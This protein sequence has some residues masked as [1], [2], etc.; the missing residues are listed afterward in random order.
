MSF[1]A[2]VIPVFGSQ[3]AYADLNFAAG[4]FGLDGRIVNDITSLPGFTFTRA[5]LA[6]GYDATG[7]LTYG[8][9]NLCLQ[10]QTFDNAYWTKTAA[11]ITADATT[12][13]DG[14]LTA[15]RLIEDTSTGTHL[16]NRDITSSRG[17]TQCYSIYLKVGLGSARKYRLEWFDGASYVWRGTFDPATNTFSSI[18]TAG[19]AYGSVDVGNGWYRVYMV[20]AVAN[21]SASTL[22]NQYLV[23]GASTSY[24]GDGTSGIYLWGAQLEA[25][26]YQTTPSTYYP[27]TSAAY[28]G[29]RLVYDPVTLAS[30]GILVEEART[31]VALQ[32]NALGTTPWG[33]TNAGVGTLPTVTNNYAISP[34]GT[35]NA[36]RIQ[37]SL[38]GGT[39][40]GD[41]SLVA[42]A[43]TTSG[44]AQGSF[45]LKTTD[46]ST[47]VVYLRGA[48]ATTVTVTGTWQR[49]EFAAST[50]SG[51]QFAVGL[52]GGQAL[53]CSNTC[54]ILVYGAQLEV[55]VG[56]SSPIPTTTAAVTR[57]ADVPLVTGLSVPYPMS[58]AVDFATIIGPVTATTQA[59]TV[60]DTGAGVDEAMLYVSGSGSM[61]LYSEAGASVECDL[62]IGGGMAANTAYKISGRWETNNFQGARNGVLGTADTS[63]TAPAAGS[64]LT[65]GSRQGGVSQIN[66]TIS[67]IRIYNR[68]L[69]DAQLQSLTA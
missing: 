20:A 31:N 63:G 32:S 67:R 15:D 57:A 1:P 44:N 35:S 42:Q 43:L 18:T 9:N 8:P 45:F 36:T 38:G 19:L 41:Q 37:C 49:F 54:D 17:A 25:V 48:S 66:G 39:T 50:L 53:A 11:S 47:K 29:P 30:L 6:M 65:I 40:T 55:G 58:M 24:T 34:D 22:V 14:T 52:R 51:T 10:S 2:N 28:Y 27:T 13:P 69:S 21:T 56:A 5:S 68:A 23:S 62:V 60:V 33:T 16:F 3:R 61:R 4:S 59:L 46:G 64:R 7:K 12:A 26:T